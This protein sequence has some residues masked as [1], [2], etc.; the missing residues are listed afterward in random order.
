M[1]KLKIARIENNMTQEDLA[2]AIGISRTF[3]SHIEN[4]IHN[5]TLNVCKSICYVLN[6]SL[7]DL[8]FEPSINGQINEIE[9][10][11]YSFHTDAIPAAHV[12][13]NLENKI[14]EKEYEKYF[15]AIKTDINHNP[16]ELQ[17]K[18]KM[19]YQTWEFLK[20]VEGINKMGQIVRSA[21]YQR[22]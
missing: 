11:W 8:F 10:R 22:V 18:M 15:E 3:M 9:S 1:K 16:Y 13:K 2:N 6:K 19:S 5:P 17:I 12:K 7:D 20:S 4:G 14:A 21:K